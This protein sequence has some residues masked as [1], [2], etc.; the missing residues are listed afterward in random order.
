MSD[1]SKPNVDQLLAALAGK[2]VVERQKA[3]NSLVEIGAAAVPGL[4][5][6]LDANQQHVR[7]E[8]AK[9]L[10]EIADPTAADALVQALGDEDTDVRWVAGEAMI[11]LKR[12]AVKPL[13]NSLTKSQD[14]EGLYKSAH[15][16]LRDLSKLRDLGPLLVPVLKALDQPEP[17]VDVPVAAQTAL[18]NLG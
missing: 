15:H 10:T 14:S 2:D 11:A 18:E 17:E 13:L 8:A 5:T 9:T 7:W 16:V 6:A 1:S 12:D 3:R 4:I